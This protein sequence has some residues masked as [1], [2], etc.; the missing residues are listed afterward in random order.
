MHINLGLKQ[1]VVIPVVAACLA[2]GIA[3][4]AGPFHP[5]SQA[6]DYKCLFNHELLIICHNKNL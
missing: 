2:A 3:G 6:V 4:A 1:R 5:T